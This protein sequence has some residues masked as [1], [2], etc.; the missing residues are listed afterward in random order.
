[1]ATRKLYIGSHGPFLYDDES[2]ID[3]PDGDFSGETVN[4]V[5]TDGPV[6]T[7]HTPT[8]PED[9]IRL[10]DLNR[11]LNA[12]TA[13]GGTSKS[14]GDSGLITR[15]VRRSTIDRSFQTRE[16]KKNLRPE[17]RYSAADRSFKLQKRGDIK[18]PYNRYALMT[19]G[20]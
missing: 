8:D 14:S 18:R 4:T 6:K 7:T 1:M 11:Y 2:P 12:Q 13:G 19:G 15:A 20:F 17:T 9:M 16:F 3:D 10:E 5:M